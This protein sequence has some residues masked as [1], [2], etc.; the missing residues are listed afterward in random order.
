MSS[1]RSAG[2]TVSFATRNAVPSSVIDVPPCAVPVSGRISSREPTRKSRSR[3]PALGSPS[4]ARSCATAA[5]AC[6]A[7]VAS[8]GSAA[9]PTRAYTSTSRMA[10]CRQRTP[11][12]SSVRR[13][14]GGS[15]SR[16]A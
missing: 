16:W 11:E 12:L 2:A 6:A 13:A 5:C 9:E 3:G 4:H 15:A 14:A 10:R 7:A 1:C 8:S